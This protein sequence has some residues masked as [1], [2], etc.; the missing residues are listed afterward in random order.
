M[1]RSLRALEQVY[2]GLVQC[3]LVHAMAS[4]FIC[5]LLPVLVLVL[6]C[7]VAG[8]YIAQITYG[9][10]NLIVLFFCL[11]Q[12]WRIVRG[13][14]SFWDLKWQKSMSQSFWTSL[15]FMRV[16]M[17]RFLHYVALFIL[18]LNVVRSVDMCNWNDR[19]AYWVYSLLLDTA[20]ATALTDML[21]PSS[22]LLVTVLILCCIV[23]CTGCWSG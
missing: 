18:I 12:I 7:L 15:L 22:P 4:K 23:V 17:Q 14:G 6:F 2:G 3:K 21:N 19:F 10:L 13:T 20:T 1:R 8:Y 9:S 5:D 11:W 16:N